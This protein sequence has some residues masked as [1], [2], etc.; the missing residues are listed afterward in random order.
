MADSEEQNVLGQFI[1]LHYHYNMLTDEARM[2]GFEEA[3][4]RVVPQGGKVL[5]L[6]GGTGVLSYFAARNAAKVWCVERNPELAQAARRILAL[7]DGGERVE[8]VEADA[9][10]YLPPEPVDVVVCEMLHVALLR[11]KQVEVIASFKKRYSAKFGP[12]LPRFVPEA[13]IQGVQP[14]QQ[15]FVNHGFYAP[16]LFFQQPGA[17]HENSTELAEP[18][19]YQ[20]VDYGSELP[21][22]CAWQGTLTMAQTGTLNAL[23]FVTKNVLAILVDEQ[24]TVDWFN[25]Y[26]IAPLDRPFEVQAGDQVRVGFKYAVGGQLEELTGSLTVQPA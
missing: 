17:I 2:G 3:L 19:L 10:E 12:T 9:F 4:A 7:N 14:V 22:E 8:V 18:T 25:Q 11:E 26:L 1:P 15:E 6:G 23:R 21:R 5:E 16:V 20:T 13:S 24:R